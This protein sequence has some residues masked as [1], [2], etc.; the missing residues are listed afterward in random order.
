MAIDFGSEYIA[1]GWTWPDLVDGCTGTRYGMG[2]LRTFRHKGLKRLYEQNNPSG[3]RPDQATRTRDV[4]AHLD[5]ALSPSDID[6]P[7][8]GSMP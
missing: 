1:R 7:G 8:T 5:R 6:L 3:V 2:V 4:L